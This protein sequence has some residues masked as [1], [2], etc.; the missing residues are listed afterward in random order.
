MVLQFRQFLALAGALFCASAQAGEVTVAVAANFTAPMQKIAN[1][2]RSWRLGLLASSTHKSK[3][4]RH[5][6]CCWQRMMKHLHV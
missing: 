1:T 2:K 4:R 3:T 5:L 6:L